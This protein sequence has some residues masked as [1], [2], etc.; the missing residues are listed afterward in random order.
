MGQRGDR[1]TVQRRQLQQQQAQQSAHRP[2]F[3]APS[4]ELP[5]KQNQTVHNAISER[6][7]GVVGTADQ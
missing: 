7:E 6:F 2:R 1:A 3:A 4:G 5:E